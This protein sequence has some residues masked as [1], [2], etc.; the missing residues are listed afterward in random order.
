[1]RGTRWRTRELISL[2]GGRGFPAR[3][4]ITLSLGT[5]GKRAPPIAAGLAIE[6]RCLCC[7]RSLCAVPQAAGRVDCD[8]TCIGRL[9]SQLDIYRRER[10]RHE[11][12]ISFRSRSITPTG[13][14]QKDCSNCRRTR[15]LSRPVRRSG[16][17]GWA[18]LARSWCYPPVRT[19]GHGGARKTSRQ[20][21]SRHRY[22]AKGF[23]GG[24]A[25]QNMQTQ[26]R[27]ETASALDQKIAALRNARKLA[28]AL[29]VGRD[30]Q[31]SPTR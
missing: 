1:V 14:K 17:R 16:T 19:R 29:R 20:S 6:M 26:A 8:Q 31:V 4:K 21:Y 22:I 13:S 23:R 7:W 10:Q 30:R 15:T 2:S 27:Q 24:E 28:K 5:L 11:N 18:G 12:G 9:R 3:E 25:L